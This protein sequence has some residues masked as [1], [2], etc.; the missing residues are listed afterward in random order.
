[1]VE[2]NVV[3][4]VTVIDVPN[5]DLQLKPG[6]TA[7]VTVE[8]ARATDVLV[9][10]NAALRV[11]PGPDVLPTVGR[12]T[13]DA[14]EP[15]PSGGHAAAGSGEA[16]GE[17]WIMVEGTLDR[18]PVRVGVSD[19]TRSAVFSPALAEGLKVVT[20]ISADVPATPAAS[21][22]PLLPSFRGRG[23]G[24]GRNAG[25]PPPQR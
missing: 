25:G 20:A 8:V 6:M 2:Q 21:T 13:G 18:V 14:D 12:R 10:P 4:Y 7:T 3:S 17:I 15:R 11:R 22:S 23:G 24:A 19:G 16:R 1:V 9:V 5:P